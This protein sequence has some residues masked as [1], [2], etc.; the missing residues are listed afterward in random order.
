VSQRER[1]REREREIERERERERERNGEFK[2]SYKIAC[3]ILIDGKAE[4]TIAL[5][6][7]SR[8]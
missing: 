4:N 2:L 5:F 8:A 6:K 1:E 3:S 7:S